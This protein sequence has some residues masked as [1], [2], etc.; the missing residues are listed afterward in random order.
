MVEVRHHQQH[1]VEA[2]VVVAVLMIC[3]QHLIQETEQ[4]QLWVVTVVI[5]MIALIT[6]IIIFKDYKIKLE[7]L[8][9]IK[10]EAISTNGVGKE[11]ERL[12]AVN[13]LPLRL[14]AIC[15]L[16]RKG[17]HCLVLPMNLCRSSL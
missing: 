5:V 8:N 12:S 2:V 13:A 10:Y 7:T 14:S 3:H 4:E 6:L 16:P 9:L 1:Q 15:R 11:N 17:V